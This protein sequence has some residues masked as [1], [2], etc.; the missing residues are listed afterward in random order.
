L[1]FPFVQ[2]PT[3]HIQANPHDYLFL[4]LMQVPKRGITAGELRHWHEPEQQ[5]DDKPQTQV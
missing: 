5:S 2:M 4:Q 3:Q 1:Q